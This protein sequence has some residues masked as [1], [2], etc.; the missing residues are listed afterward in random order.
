[1]YHYRIFETLKN[2]VLKMCIK[3]GGWK[4]IYRHTQY[5]MHQY[6]HILEVHWERVDVRIKL[7]FCTKMCLSPASSIAPLSLPYH[8][9]NK[10]RLTDECK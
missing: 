3:R 9:P 1:M 2:P 10:W 6:N 4:C 7:P 8:S 5:S